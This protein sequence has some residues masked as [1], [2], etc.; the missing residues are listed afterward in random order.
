MK[1]PVH[2]LSLTCLQRCK[3]KLMMN[4]H[5]FM[6]PTCVK[7]GLMEFYINIIYQNSHGSQVF[8]ATLV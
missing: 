5:S 2:Y 7:L 8:D 4:I 3:E 1:P 6:S